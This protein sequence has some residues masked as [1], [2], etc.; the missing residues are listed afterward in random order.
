MQA[1]I[2][3][4][5]VFLLGQQCVEKVLHVRIAALYCTTGMYF[6]SVSVGRR[7]DEKFYGAPP[8]WVQGPSA[9][10]LSPDLRV[11]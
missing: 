10:G 11:G 1:T 7:P 3:T 2:V 4:S 5:M 9:L 8:A 6:Y